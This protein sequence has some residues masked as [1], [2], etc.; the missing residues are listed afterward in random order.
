MIGQ[1]LGGLK[2]TAVGEELGDASGSEAVV[3]EY[4]WNSGFEESS[5]HHPKRITPRH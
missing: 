4:G 1:L 3:R 2:I 5:F